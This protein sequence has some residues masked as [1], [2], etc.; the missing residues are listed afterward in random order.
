MGERWYHHFKNIICKGQIINF[1]IFFIFFLFTLFLVSYNSSS[2]RTRRLA[3]SH[4]PRLVLPVMALVGCYILIVAAE[5]V[6]Y[7]FCGRYSRGTWRSSQFP[8]QK[9]WVFMY[10][11]QS[12][13]KTMFNAF[14]KIIY[15]W[16]Y[17]Y[18]YIWKEVYIRYIGYIL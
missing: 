5:P 2:L 1:L 9:P 8:Q 14:S 13:N 17:I 10:M 7:V 3:N 11:T 16:L 4:R 12:R 15:L 18:I 6:I